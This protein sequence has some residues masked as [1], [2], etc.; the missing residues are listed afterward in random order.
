MAIRQQG[1]S[2][3][4]ARKR[5]PQ[6]A[7]GMALVRWQRP[8]PWLAAALSLALTACAVGPDYV[9]PPSDLSP[10]FVHAA[11]TTDTTP[12]ALDVWWTRFNDP[13][14]SAIITRVLSQNLDLAAAQ[15]R[16]AQARAVARLASAAL[17]PVGS[18]NAQ[19]AGQ[20][21]SLESPIGE[22][23]SHQPGYQRNATLYSAGVGASWELDLAG[24]LRR[25]AEADIAEAQA[26]EADHMGVRVSVAAEAA[27]AYLRVRGAQHRM[28][29]ATAQLSADNDLLRLVELRLHE[30]MSTQR[31]QA[32][33]QARV[34][35]I[36]ATLPPLQAER[37]IQLNRLDVLMGVQP[38][39]YATQLAATASE[40]SIPALATTLTPRDL[41]RRRPDVI[42]AERRLA[43]SSARIGSAVAEYYPQFS[44]SA[45]LGFESL[46]SATPDAANFQPLALLG[47]RWRLFDFGRVDAE[48]ARAQGV[49]AEALARYR[50]SMLRA[51]EDV[52]NALLMQAAQAAEHRALLRE[53]DASARA[54]DSS[55]EAYKGG[56]TSLME[57]LEQD[58]ELLT[59]RD[60]LVRAQTGSARAV[61][62]TFRAL[63]GGW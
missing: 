12:L 44:L 63:G 61:V 20:R 33:A 30:G 14:L 45:L 10:A 56:A 31:E 48:V 21:Q 51:A 1:K 52:E 32:Q 7:S 19:V 54:R 4:V 9:L 23:A 39:T 38:G 8:R 28:A 2:A 25:G 11:P 6:A 15:A 34:A 59:A 42:A 43:A 50:Q 36:S 27:D 41:L 35:Q 60:Q 40:V 22:L 53:V 57:V 5:S 17:L 13:Q 58:R 55:E 37:D 49:N 3:P 47:V 24:G 29:L 26:A 62:A 16:V 46:H 18:A